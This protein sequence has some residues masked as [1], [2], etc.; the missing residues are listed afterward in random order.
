VLPRLGEGK[1]KELGEE[2]ERK[3]MREKG[4]ERWGGK[5]WKGRSTEAL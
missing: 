2:N 3:T 1:R 4:V 5:T